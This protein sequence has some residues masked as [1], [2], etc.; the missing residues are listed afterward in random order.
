MATALSYWRWRAVRAAERIGLPGLAAAVLALALAVA[1][2]ALAVPGAHRLAQLDA[3]NARL[4]RQATLRASSARGAPVS[5]ADRLAAFENG[6]PRP[7]VLSQSYSR[8]WTLAR[9]HGLQLRQAD[10]KLADAGQDA[11]I[12]YAI[13]VPLSTEYA[14]LRAFVAE[15]LRDN[16][17]LALEEMSLRRTDARSTQLDARLRFVLFVRRTE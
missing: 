1:W 4:A 14:P 7:Q 5:S 15:A 9:Q 10:F 12:R 3:E 17:A 11:V 13:V 8:L 6:F 16:P 2:L